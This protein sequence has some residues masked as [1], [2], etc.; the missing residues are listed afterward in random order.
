MRVKLT[1]ADYPAQPVHIACM[2]PM[3]D[4]RSIDRCPDRA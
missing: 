3:A 4:M 1:L 2:K